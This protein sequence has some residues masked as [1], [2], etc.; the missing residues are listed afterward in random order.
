[1][2]SSAKSP[3]D[4]DR[5][6]SNEAPQFHAIDEE[7]N[8]EPADES[9]SAVE[10]PLSQSPVENI[11]PRDDH[12][13]SHEASLPFENLSEP[14]QYL[15]EYS[16]DRDASGI[17]NTAS[18][19]KHLDEDQ[20][21]RQPGHPDHTSANPPDPSSLSI[22]DVLP[23]SSFRNFKAR[24]S[25]INRYPV[26]SLTPSSHT[27]VDQ[28]SSFPTIKSRGPDVATWKGVVNKIE[29]LDKAEVNSRIEA[30][31]IVQ[32]EEVEA[33]VQGDKDDANVNRS[34][35]PK[36]SKERKDIPSTSGEEEPITL[37]DVVGRIY[38]FPWPICKTWKVL[39]LIP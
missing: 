10:D 3:M 17:K 5:N 27:P 33:T 4:D 2:K 16:S 21:V 23:T 29:V 9:L 24:S 13:E 35:V 11:P 18:S 34:N 20:A 30:D 1:M 28:S 37:K 36:T 39:I 14:H 38:T 12:L 32:G 15:A 6:L 31:R 22:D 8:M 26:S 19:S 25:I 7:E